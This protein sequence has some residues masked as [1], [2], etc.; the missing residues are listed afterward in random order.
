[1]NV[2]KWLGSPL[3]FCNTYMLMTS[4]KSANLHC[5]VTRFFTSH[6]MVGVRNTRI[7]L[8]NLQTSCIFCTV[9]IYIYMCVCVCVCVCVCARVYIYIYVHYKSLYLKL[10]TNK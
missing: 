1:M 3:Q 9:S 7:H 2:H 5:E 8:Y 10:N 4:G 6:I